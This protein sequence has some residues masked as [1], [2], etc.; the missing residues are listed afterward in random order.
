MVYINI[1][2]INVLLRLYQSLIVEKDDEIVMMRKKFLIVGNGNVSNALEC[3]MENY[4]EIE[5]RIIGLRDLS[6]EKWK[7]IKEICKDVDVIIYTIGNG[8][9]NESIFWEHKILIKFIKLC[10]TDTNKFIFMSS[11]KVYNILES[12]KE[13]NIDC[14]VYRKYNKIEMICNSLIKNELNIE[15][16]NDELANLNGS[17]YEVG[18]IIEENII[19]KLIKDYIILRSAYLYGKQEKNNYIYKIVENIISN[20]S[21]VIELFKYE[22]DFVEYEYIFKV[23][24]RAVEIDYKGIINVGTGRFIHRKEIKL[25]IKKL[26]LYCE[27]EKTVK[28]I[29]IGTPNKQMSLKRVN[30]LLNIAPRK[31]D[32]CFVEIIYLIY[33]EKKLGFSVLEEY[34]GGSYARVYKVMDNNNKE[35]LVKISIGNGANNG[36][37]KLCN[38]I[39]QGIRLGREFKWINEFL[40]DVYK[41]KAMPHFSYINREIVNGI[42]FEEINDIRQK[43]QFLNDMTI[44]ISEIYA[45]T[46]LV[47]KENMITKNITRVIERINMVKKVA[48][49]DDNMCNLMDSSYIYINNKKYENPIDVLKYINDHS[50]VDFDN[51][52]GPCISGDAIPDNVMLSNN[53]YIFF[54][55]RGEDLLWVNEVPYFD[56]IYD[57]GKILFYFLG[58]KEIR[59]QVMDIVVNGVNDFIVEQREININFYKKCE[60]IF[61]ECKNIIQNKDNEKIFLFKIYLMAGMHF[62]SDTY[63]RMVGKGNK[64]VQCMQEYI[65]GTIIINNCKYL[66]DNNMKNL[67][68]SRWIRREY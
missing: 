22:R 26:L 6:K 25:W 12:T 41:Y 39:I 40:P 18:K 11:S 32:E 55:Q 62:L 31:F 30:E 59:T 42:K 9:D 1:K 67:E 2:E 38:E 63:P 58:W 14:N 52:L 13:V 45:D 47:I 4:V 20:K 36:A 33:I 49:K 51:I 23:I 7:N 8:Q 5:K 57:Y 28:Y 66:I 24:M 10:V 16:Y 48:D 64:L 15:E 60:K 46:K 68:F 61:L 50:Q 29:D 34:F 54:D 19:S 21:N 56:P 37:K 44:K 35:S 3:L 65:V 27:A 43:E 53:H 17:A